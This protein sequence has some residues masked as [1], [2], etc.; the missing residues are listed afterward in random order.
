M[1]GGEVIDETT[2]EGYACGLLWY[3]TGDDVL[4]AFDATQDGNNAEARLVI[5]RGYDKLNA[6]NMVRGEI[7][8]GLSGGPFNNPSDGEFSQ[9]F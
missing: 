5:K 3:E 6:L 1:V 8:T 7:A 2:P 4:I 9:T